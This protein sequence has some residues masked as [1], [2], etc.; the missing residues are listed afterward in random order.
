MNSK[1]QLAGYVAAA[2]LIAAGL[3]LWLYRVPSFDWGKVLAGLRGADPGWLAAAVLFVSLS[4]LVRAERWRVMLRPLRAD[5]SFWRLLSATAIGFTGSM[6][7]G[8][9]GEMIRPYLIARKEGVSVSS[10][11]AIWVAERILDL[12]M[13]LVLFG[14]GLAR[15]SA[16]AGPKSAMVMQAG[17]WALGVMSLLCLLAVAMFRYYDDGVRQRLTDALGFIPDEARLRIAEFLGSFGEGMRAT[18]DG[19]GLASLLLYSTVEWLVLVLCAYCTL[20]ALPGTNALT[21]ADSIVVLGFVSFGHSVQLPGIGGGSQVASLFVL[22]ELYG[23]SPEN[24]GIAAI[25]MWAVN[26]LTV[27]PVGVVLAFVEGLQWKE[28]TKPL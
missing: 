6:F 16:M 9:A 3:A 17:G 18:R 15:V 14:F 19:R 1:R 7:L 20:R 4:Y 23:V 26:I 2:I 27:V 21:L 24:A 10:Q 28:M 22:T 12:L 11:I 5:A 13:V 8:R 25:M